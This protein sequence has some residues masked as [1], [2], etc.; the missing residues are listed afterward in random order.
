MK[1]QVGANHRRNSQFET[2]S[3]H[4]ADFNQQLRQKNLMNQV[5]NRFISTCFNTFQ[6][7]AYESIH[8]QKITAKASSR[9][10]T[11]MN[12]IELFK[13]IQNPVSLREG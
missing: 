6:I 5:R 2:S 3:A 1:S 9:K 7:F 11:R 13:L 10:L 12:C 4:A 8:R